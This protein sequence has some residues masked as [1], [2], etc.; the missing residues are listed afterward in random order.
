MSYTLYY[1]VLPFI[2]MSHSEHLTIFVDW[3]SPLS[4]RQYFYT[5]RERTNRMLVDAINRDIPNETIMS[6]ATSA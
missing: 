6:P 5:L 1:K 3:F 2:N 4:A